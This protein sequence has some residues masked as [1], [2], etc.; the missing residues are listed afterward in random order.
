MGR[1]QEALETF[2]KNLEDRVGGE[3]SRLNVRQLERKLAR[4]A[5]AAPAAP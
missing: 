3:I 5:A 1:D 2:R 4:E